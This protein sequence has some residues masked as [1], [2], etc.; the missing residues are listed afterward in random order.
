MEAEEPVADADNTPLAMAKR[1]LFLRGKGKVEAAFKWGLKAL[2]LAPHDVLVRDLVNHPLSL[3]VPG[4]HAAMLQDERRNACYAAAIA[5]VVRPG[6]R[7]LEI[8][9]GAGLLA[10][11]AARAGGEVYTC[12]A[13]PVVAS[14][15]REIVARNGLSGRVHVIPKASTEI[16]VGI[17]LP[18]R[19]DVL[20]SEL[21]SEDL[22]GEG[23]EPTLAHARDHLLSPSAAIVPP[24]ATVRCAL[25]S[26]DMPAG[27]RPVGT[28][29]GFDLSPL[30]AISRPASRRLRVAAGNA[31]PLSR[32]VDLIAADFRGAPPFSPRT[33]SV[34]VEAQAGRVGAVVY[35]LAIDFGDG[36]TYENDPWAGTA[37]HWRPVVQPL[38]PPIDAAAGDRFSITARRIGMLLT[39]SAVPTQSA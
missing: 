29:H 39:L 15:A 10:M 17:D 4:W 9:T 38:D 20:V 24:A 1:A 33:A 37:S 12:E 5:A 25:A 32:P 13:N 19:A 27:Q 18:W 23:V 6:T 21:F 16:A 35:W 14:V 22:F 2:E 8:G 28:V 3:G 30:N 36:I 31:R 26:F 7:V 34:D 11:M